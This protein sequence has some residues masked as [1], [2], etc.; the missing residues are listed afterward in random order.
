[1][2]GHKDLLVG[3]VKTRMSRRVSRGFDASERV[4]TT[5]FYRITFIQDAKVKILFE[6][7]SKAGIALQRF[8]KLIFWEAI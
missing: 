1:M 7:I 4:I 8:L 5:N 3:L 2:T 6:A